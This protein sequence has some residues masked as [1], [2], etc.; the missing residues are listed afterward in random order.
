[1]P[2]PFLRHGLMG[3]VPSGSDKSSFL[4]ERGVNGARVY[5]EDVLQEL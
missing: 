5:Q 4:Q 1:M 2:S 3:D